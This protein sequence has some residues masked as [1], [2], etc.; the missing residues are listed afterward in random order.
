MGCP[1]GVW[2]SDDI[3]K[4]QSSNVEAVTS[5]APPRSAFPFYCEV[6]STG[7]YQ[8]SRRQIGRKTTQEQLAAPA[9]CGLREVGTLRRIV[10]PAFRAKW[11]HLK[12]R[13]SCC[14]TRAPVCLR[15]KSTTSES[16]VAIPHWSLTPRRTFSYCFYCARQPLLPPFLKQGTL[17]LRVTAEA[18]LPFLLGS[19]GAE[20][21]QS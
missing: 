7:H 8:A 19:L 3:G 5:H 13:R 21:D 6:C 17:Y 20:E 1:T 9:K 12:V 11:M 2:K 18:P 4:S 16:S 15:S 14:L 10:S